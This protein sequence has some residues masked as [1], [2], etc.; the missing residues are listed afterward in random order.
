MTDP[1]NGILASIPARYVSVATDELP[2][3]STVPWKTVRETELDVPG[4][5]RVRFTAVSMVSKKGRSTTH[6]WS[7]IRAVRVDGESAY[8]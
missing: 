5:G 8:G 3:A 7:V 2:E 1:D 6:W 4:I